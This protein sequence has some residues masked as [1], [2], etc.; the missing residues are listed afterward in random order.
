MSAYIS[1]L[2]YYGTA[3]AEFVEIAV[4]AGTDV[5]GY[6]I[7]HYDGFGTVVDTF[8]LGVMTGTMGGKDVYVLDDRTA[9]WDY[10]DPSGTLWADDALAL[11]DDTGSVLQFVSW[12]GYTVTAIAGPAAGQ[13]SVNVGTIVDIANG[14]VQSD[15]GGSTYFSQSSQNPDVIPACYATGT[16]IQTLIGPR[17]V[18]TLRAGDALTIAQG[19]PV[20]VRWVYAGATPAEAAAT[21]DAVSIPAHAMGPGRPRRPLL[22]S[23]QHRVCVGGFGQFATLFSAPHFLPAKALIGL[24]GVHQ[25]TLPGSSQ[26]HH[27]ACARHHVIAAEGLY[28]ETMLL[29]PM[30]V[31]A[32]PVAA[33]EEVQSLFGHSAGS[34][35]LNGT[36]ALPCLTVGAAR[37]AIFGRRGPGNLSPRRARARHSAFVPAPCLT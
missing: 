1:E 28:S 32:L 35:P 17:P 9:G 5:S 20:T 2:D 34:A 19:D 25:V 33:R 24:P 26:W 8:S 12:Q 7:V 15:D 14:S 36:P 11:V 10:G 23:P 16:R 21:A 30:A 22:V 18:E 27:L 3:D 4:A 31:S 13:T 6:T 37:Q 29:G